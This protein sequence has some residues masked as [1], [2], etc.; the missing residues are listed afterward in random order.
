MY[1]KNRSSPRTDPWG[2]PQFKV[3]RTDLYPFIDT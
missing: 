2:A 1:S 3:A